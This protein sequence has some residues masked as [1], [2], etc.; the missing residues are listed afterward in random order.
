MHKSFGYSPMSYKGKLYI[1]FDLE[2]SKTFQN[3]LE[4]TYNYLKF[5]RYAPKHHGHGDNRI[6]INN[7][8]MSMFAKIAP[9]NFV[10]VG[11]KPSSLY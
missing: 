9:G 4:E 8:N 7:C 1:G 10:D 11:T 5:E 3:Y 2:L 6:A